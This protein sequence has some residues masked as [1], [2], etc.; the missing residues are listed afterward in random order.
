[1][2]DKVPVRILDITLIIGSYSVAVGYLRRRAV[3]DALEDGL[4]GRPIRWRTSSLFVNIMR[5]YRTPSITWVN[6]FGRFIKKYYIMLVKCS[7]LC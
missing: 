2:D 6:T 3:C 5:L 4:Y 7:A 1:M